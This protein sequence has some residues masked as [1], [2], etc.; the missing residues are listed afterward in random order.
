MAT[1]EHLMRASLLE[2]FNE[3]DAGRRRAAIDRTYSP[4][5]AFADPEG[6]VVGRDAVDAKARQILDRAPG[7]GFRPDGPVLVR[8]DLGYL[9]WQFGPAG[10]PPVVRGMDIALIEDGLIAHLYTLLPEKDAG[11][12]EIERAA[13]EEP[14]PPSRRR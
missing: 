13:D 11:A 3:R 8:E 7:F 10:A 4:S 1:L 12:A 9:A 5:V 2:V 14:A 6:R